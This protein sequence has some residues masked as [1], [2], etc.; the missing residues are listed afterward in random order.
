LLSSGD[1][2]IVLFW[3]SFATAEDIALANSSASRPL[4]LNF[5]QEQPAVDIKYSYDRVKRLN[6]IDDSGI[7]V[8]VASR[9]MALMKT[10]AAIEETV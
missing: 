6:V 5:V 7:P 1:P 3:L 10:Q 9:G 8:L 4:L 2:R